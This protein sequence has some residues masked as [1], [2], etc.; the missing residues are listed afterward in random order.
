LIHGCFCT[1]A[2][3]NVPSYITT[4]NLLLCHSLVRQAILVSI[5]DSR[6]LYQSFPMRRPPTH[7][8]FGRPAVLALSASSR[9]RPKAFA[10]AHLQLPGALK[11][12]SHAGTPPLRSIW[13]RLPFIKLH[14]YFTNPGKS[15]DPN[16]H[17]CNDYSFPL[18]LCIRGRAEKKPFQF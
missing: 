11:S 2:D 7:Q 12:C 8:A 16:T 10:H 4:M 1:D 14:R 5:S 18:G 13:Q 9:I 15:F 6:S 3:D 17:R